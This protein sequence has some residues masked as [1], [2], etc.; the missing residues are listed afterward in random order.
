MLLNFS[1]VTLFKKL[2]AISRLES[3]IKRNRLHFSQVQTVVNYRKKYILQHQQFVESLA[4]L[5]EIIRIPFI[6]DEVCCYSQLSFDEVEKIVP[7][8]SP[9]LSTNCWFWRIFFSLILRPNIR[10]L[11]LS[12]IRLLQKRSLRCLWH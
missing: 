5:S 8:S 4:E 6:S 2:L 11:T 9:K 10:I 7:F 12:V 3:L 1:A